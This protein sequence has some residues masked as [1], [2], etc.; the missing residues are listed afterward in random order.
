MVKYLGLHIDRKLNWSEHWSAKCATGRKRIRY[1]NS[2]FQY[3]NS[4]ARLQL[5]S[6]LVQSVLDYCPSVAWSFS[7]MTVKEVENCAG[8]FLRTIRLG[9]SNKWSTDERYMANALEISWTSQL[10]RRVKLTLLFA[11]KLIMG[12]VPLGSLFFQ[13]YLFPSHSGPSASTRRQNHLLNHPC[14]IQPAGSFF[15]GKMLP[16]C[17]KSFVHVV[18][19]I[20]NGLNFPTDVLKFN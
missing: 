1:I 5:F 12:T 8:K 13:S 9:F 20:W 4:A 11:Y 2:L 15:N 3:R 19:T 18:C 10:V 6:S 7:I 16:T 17:Q 14:P